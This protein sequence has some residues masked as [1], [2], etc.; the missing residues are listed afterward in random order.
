MPARKAGGYVRKGVLYQGPTMP[1][2]VK[3]VIVNKAN[4][5]VVAKAVNKQNTSNISKIVRSVLRK[6]E[7]VKMVSNTTITPT[8]GQLV[9]GAGLS[10]AAAAPNQG[11]VSLT[12]LIPPL[13]I[14]NTSDTRI[15][16][17]INPK[18]LTVRYS[19]YANP[20]TQADSTGPIVN[21]FIG[22]PFRVKVIVFRHRFAIDEPSQV[23]IINNGAVNADLSDNI[24]TFFRP[25]NKDEYIIAYTKMYKMQPPR[26]LMTGSTSYT[27]QSQDS[28][29]KSMVIKSI[30]L[31]LPKLRYNDAT[32][33]A[34]NSQWYLAF[35]VCNEDSSAITAGSQSRITVN[36]ESH[37]RYTDA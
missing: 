20:S 21:P 24:D 33:T 23:G 14:G 12:G 8:K 5:K 26:H 11:W 31:R 9:Y 25:Y 32:T 30:N 3:Q 13:A 16:N 22:L 15:G 19:I 27:G 10:Y 28:Y 36:V 17:K 4:K 29:A 7:E 2:S 35:A 6:D 18:G 1:K 34:S 37:M